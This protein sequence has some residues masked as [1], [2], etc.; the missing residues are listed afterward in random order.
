MTFTGTPAKMA[1][2]MAGMPSGVPG[3][4]M[5]RLGRPARACSSLATASVV[6][7]SR[8]SS[9]DTSSDTK[10]STPSVRSYTGRKRSAARVMSSSASSKKSA[11]PDLPALS[12][13]RM[14]A[15]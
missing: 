8:A 6:L 11:S 9:G 10:P 15:S 1:S 5:N 13:L 7:V 2:S 12:L 3:I 4:L 14:A